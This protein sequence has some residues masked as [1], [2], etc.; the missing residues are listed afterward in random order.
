MKVFDKSQLHHFLCGNS[1]G[2][3][4]ATHGL[5]EHEN[6]LLLETLQW[7]GRYD[8]YYSIVNI[9]TGKIER[10]Y[11]IRNHLGYTEPDIA[12]TN[13]DN[14]AEDKGI[15][16]FRNIIHPFVRE[17]HDLFLVNALKLFPQGEINKIRLRDTRFIINI[18]VRKKNGI[19]VFVKQMVLPF[20]VDGKGQLVSY[21]NVYTIV[22]EYRG[23]P[24]RPRFFEHATS[25]QEL[26]RMRN[27]L[28][29]EHKK[30]A[31]REISITKYELMDAFLHFHKGMNDW[32]KPVAAHLKKEPASVR[33]LITEAIMP[34]A[35]KLFIE[36]YRE[37]AEPIKSD[38]YENFMEPLKNFESMVLFLKKSGILSVLFEVYKNKSGEIRENQ[39]MNL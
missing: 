9:K 28:E 35:R 15:Y 26:D 32:K 13:P 36:P 3:G 31:A 25:Q 33:W 6:K 22:D 39:M 29:K 2:L 7:M 34:K 18:P 10:Q 16:F 19:Y 1:K 5:E 17:W 27:K 37:Q 23:Q 11:G 14:P 20:Q 8:V 24:L 38:N 12:G 21:L 4:E 30:A